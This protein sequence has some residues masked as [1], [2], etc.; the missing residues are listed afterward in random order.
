VR[1][2]TFKTSGA[3]VALA[4]VVL[5]GALRV[6]PAAEV[7]RVGTSGDYSP[8]SFHD[9]T[10]ALTG[11]DI[12]V[13]RRLAADLGRELAF[14]PFRWSELVPQLRAGAFDIAMSGVTVRADR[15][16]QV[17]FSRPY[18]VTG[19]VVVR[20]VRDRNKFRRLP[21]VDHAG[22]RIA[23]N[24]GGHLEQIARQRFPH[25]RLL[26]VTDNAS[27]PDALR[28][29]RTDVV[30]SEALEAR[31]WPRRQFAT[32]GPFT[33]D[34]KAY[35]VPRQAADL[36]QQVNDWLA[37]READGWLN[38]QR[39]QWL[40]APAALSERQAALEALVAAMDLR[41]QLM[42]F[43]AAVKRRAGLQIDD[44]AQEARVLAHVRE[45]AAVAGLNVD[46]VAAVFQ[47]QID[48]AKAVE[49]APRSAD[50]VPAVSLTD[51]RAAVASVSDQIIAE[52]GR[53]RHWLSDP[54]SRAQLETTVRSGLT[55]PGVPLRL[56]DDLLV[57][58]HGVR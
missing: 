40:G 58:L 35:A 44:P 26:L 25:A 43:I 14:V 10:D 23:V 42:P 9:A 47:V 27:L 29:G 51:V 48:A 39:R 7:L 20:R 18:A 16:V 57:A 41:L 31:T 5:V 8:F 22:V 1:V 12:V 6:A 32:L 13:A 55:T 21:E 56:M 11:F 38:E 4:V 37:A 15:A 33:R 34:R 28:H 36:L 17:T 54:A 24:A 49:R 52:L 45:A 53:C 19:A 2:K 50:P 3:A 46:A 30:I